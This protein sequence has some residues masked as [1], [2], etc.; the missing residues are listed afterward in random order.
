M[1][2]FQCED[3]ELEKRLLALGFELGFDVFI[4]KSLSSE[5]FS[6]KIF[7]GNS[8]QEGFHYYFDKKKDSLSKIVSLLEG[9]SFQERPFR[10][11]SFKDFF[12]IKEGEPV[13]LDGW[14]RNIRRSKKFAFLSLYD[15]T[16]EIQVFTEDL[17]L[18]Q[19]LILGSSLSLVGRV[20]LGPKEKELSLESIL[21]HQ[22]P[23]ESYPLQKKATSYEHL[24]S[25]LHL[26]TRTQSLGIVLKLR[27][28][29]SIATHDFF[30][31]RDFFYIHTPIL[32]GLDCEGGGEL[33]KVEQLKKESFFNKTVYLTVTGQLQAE[34][35]ALSH[36][37][38]YTF[39]PTFRAENSQTTRHLAEFWMIEP[40]VAFIQFE[41]L[42]HLAWSYVFYL[43]Q[44]IL[45]EAQQDLV[46]LEKI[47]EK[48]LRS[49][50]QEFSKSTLK[51][52]SYGEAITILTEHKNQFEEK[53]IFWGMDLKTEHERFLVESYQ[54]GPLAIINYPKD[55]KAFYMKQEDKTVQCFDLLVPG[56]GELIGGSMREDN[57]E[58]LLR[59]IQELKMKKEDYDWYLDLRRYGGIHHGGFGLGFE[60]L[61]LWITQLGNIREVSLFPRSV[62][63]CDL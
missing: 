26:R 32:T 49:P 40:E 39:G 54:M 57:Y 20:Q 6:L 56:V 25:L 62:Y 51:T 17:N 42:L 29:L 15:G 50:L 1:L 7:L 41:E 61:L 4:G 23:D 19:N 53:N 44:R 16:G 38:V 33:F 35:L 12:K 5:F 34:A 24:R 55:L 36:K 60:R 63:Q 31:K 21:Y 48:D 45:Q 47:L 37:K 46:I 59:R 52:L 58:K 9:R 22:V 10:N 43:V 27:N 3:Q 8:L 28:L 30:Q 18:V 11:P 2:K 13:Q 14:L